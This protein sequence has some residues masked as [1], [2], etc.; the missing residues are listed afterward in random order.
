MYEEGY[1]FL[2]PLPAGLSP[3]GLSYFANAYML[4]DVDRI[5]R[6][7]KFMILLIIGFGLCY[8]N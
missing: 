8:L 4:L 3:A 6:K 1:Y 7:G 2:P 5:L